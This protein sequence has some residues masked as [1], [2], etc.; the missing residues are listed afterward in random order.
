MRH[1]KTTEKMTI[2]LR[3]V[4]LKHEE[5]DVILS[6]EKGWKDLIRDLNKMNK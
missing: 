3:L 4:H 2:F 6:K 5:A 1:Q